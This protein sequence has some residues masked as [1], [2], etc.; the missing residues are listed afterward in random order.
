MAAPKLVAN[1]GGVFIYSKDPVA[2]AKW[3]ETHLGMVPDFSVE[4]NTIG[5]AYMYAPTVEGDIASS[6]IVWSINKLKD[7]DGA[8]GHQSAI[9]NY[10]VFDMAAV[11]SHL[12]SLGIE[13]EVKHYPGEGYF[14]HLK[15]LDG[16]KLELWQDEFTYDGGN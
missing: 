4:G 15:D 8:L 9:V 6:A 1:I 7:E 10:R 14:A 13:L 5:K 2:L 12:A 11:E 16:N 3:Y